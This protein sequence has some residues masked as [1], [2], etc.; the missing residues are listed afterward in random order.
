MSALPPEALLAARQAV[1]GVV[2]D[3][4]QNFLHSDGRAAGVSQ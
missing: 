2:R 4:I 1:G 3:K